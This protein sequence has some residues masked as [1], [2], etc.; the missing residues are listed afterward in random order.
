MLWVIVVVIGV[1]K[2]VRPRKSA[3]GFGRP[4]RGRVPR[5]GV[6]CNLR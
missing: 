3:K 4:L 5:G 1:I 2:G 6:E